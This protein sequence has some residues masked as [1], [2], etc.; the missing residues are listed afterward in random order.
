MLAGCRIIVRQL[1]VVTPTSLG[2]DSWQT[3]QDTDE[4]L[5]MT[6]SVL[7][8]VETHS[9]TAS[10]TFAHERILQNVGQSEKSPV[11]LQY[12]L[13]LLLFSLLNTVSLFIVKTWTYISN[14]K[15]ASLFS[16]AFRMTTQRGQQQRRIAWV[17]HLSAKVPA[18]P[19]HYGTQC[20]LSIVI[21]QVFSTGVG[22]IGAFNESNKTNTWFSSAGDLWFHFCW[23]I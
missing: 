15:T 14:K 22:F 17:V 23:N 7:E 19:Q 10:T 3:Q 12:C 6:R 20:L 18:A 13:S 8:S 21:C 5:G 16:V 9:W 2:L 11:I 4:T 1:K